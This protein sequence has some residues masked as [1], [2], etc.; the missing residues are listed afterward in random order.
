MLPNFDDGRSRGSRRAGHDLLEL[1]LEHALER[2]LDLVDRLVDDRVVADLDAFAVGHLGVLPS[3]RT[4][5]PMMIGVGGHREVD[6]V[7]GDRTDTA[8]D[9]PQVDVVA[10]VDLEQRLLERLDRPG[11]VALEDEVERVD[12]GRER[13]I[14]VLE[15]IRLR[16]LGQPALRSAACASRRS[17]GRSGRP[18]TTKVSP[19]RGTEVRPRPGPARRG[20]SGRP[21]RARRAWRTRP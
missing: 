12:L 7:L 21:R 17:G 2:R 13:R 6:V 20:A 8:V 15:L 9:D 14:E 4:L 18:A 5:K 1:R 19:A 3:A 10:H 16:A 11:H